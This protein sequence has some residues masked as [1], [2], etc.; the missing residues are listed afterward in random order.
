MYSLSLLKVSKML[1]AQIARLL[2]IRSDKVILLDN[3]TKL[4]LRS[5]PV[6]ELQEWSTGSGKGRD[7]LVIEFRG[8]KVS[9]LSVPLYHGIHV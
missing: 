1:F 8:N 5:H 2:G 9:H 6:C 4:L 3:K 7:G